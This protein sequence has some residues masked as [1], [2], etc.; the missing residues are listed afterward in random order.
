MP[1][2]TVSLHRWQ[3]VAAFISVTTAFVV[4]GVLLTQTINNVNH[5]RVVSCQRTYEG[6]REIFKPFFQPPKQRTHKQSRD[7]GKF[8]HRVDELKGRCDIQTGQ[9]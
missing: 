8:N 7:I 2:Q 3:I 9:R 5:D 4:Q 1:T 6:V